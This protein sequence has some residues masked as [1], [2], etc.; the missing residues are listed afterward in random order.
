VNLLNLYLSHN[1]IATL[2]NITLP[3]LIDLDLSFNMLD[4]TANWTFLTNTAVNSV[5]LGIYDLN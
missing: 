1:K 2:K 3:K 4:S 5:R